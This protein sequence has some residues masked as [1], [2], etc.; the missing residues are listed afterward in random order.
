MVLIQSGDHVGML[1]RQMSE[2]HFAISNCTVDNQIKFETD[3]LNKKEKM[4]F[5]LEKSKR[6]EDLAESGQTKLKKQEK[7]LK[8]KKLRMEAEM[9]RKNEELHT[10]DDKERTQ[11]ESKISEME[12]SD[13]NRKNNEMLKIKNSDLDEETKAKLMKDLAETDRKNKE[14]RLKQGRLSKFKISQ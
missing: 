7:S 2:L 4:M 6:Q 14:N 10:K 13:D 11:L 8:N 9:R 12:K 1:E 5:E 3:Q